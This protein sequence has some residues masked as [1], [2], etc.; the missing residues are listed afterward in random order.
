MI[1]GVVLGVVGIVFELKVFEWSVEV[2][3]VFFMLFG[4]FVLL[5]RNFRYFGWFGSVWFGLGLWEVIF[6]VLGQ[7][8]VTVLELR[9][10]NLGK[11]FFF[12]GKTWNF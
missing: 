2:I 11:T 10:N 9:G 7:V 8:L 3:W 4:Y 1:V 5:W 6:F 12:V